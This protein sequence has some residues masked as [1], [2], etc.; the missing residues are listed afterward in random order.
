MSRRKLI[1]AKILEVS[2]IFNA[3]LFVKSV[4]G[5][6][7]DFSGYQHNQKRVVHPIWPLAFA[8]LSGFFGRCNTIEKVADDAYF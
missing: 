3:H 1:D 4:K 8:M 2:K 7:T 6:L 5:L